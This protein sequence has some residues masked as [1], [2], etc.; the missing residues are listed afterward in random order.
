MELDRKG[1]ERLIAAFKTHPDLWL[2]KPEVFYTE[3]HCG[4]FALALGG[5][6]YD[7]NVHN[8]I[9]HI[10]RTDMDA[11]TDKPFSDTISH[12]CVEV[13]DVR[14]DIKGSDE[15]ESWED[16]IEEAEVD[17]DDEFYNAWSYVSVVY[18]GHENV[19][20]HHVRIISGY[21]TRFHITEMRNT[22][23]LLEETY[24]NLSKD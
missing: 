24:R 7:H 16:A 20:D 6:L 19:L 10:V 3:G 15:G 11:E 21:G 13:D 8:T 1:I 12:V 22:K 9:V 5:F 14:Y 23:R 17:D 4:T 2:E 18:T